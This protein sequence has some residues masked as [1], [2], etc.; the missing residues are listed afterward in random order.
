MDG[1]VPDS[2]EVDQLLLDGQQRLRSLSNALAGKGTLRYYFEV[3]NLA[4]NDLGVREV[5]SH[6]CAQGSGKRYSEEP[7]TAY[8]QNLIPVSILGDQ[9]GGN[10]LGAVSDWCK[11]AL[12]DKPYG[13]VKPLETEIT[14]LRTTLLERPLFYCYLCRDTPAAVALDV[15]IESNQSSHRLRTFDIVVA[16]SRKTHRDGIRERIERFRSQVPDVPYYFSPERER[17][18]PQIGDWYLKVSCLLNGEA[19]KDGNY[20]DAFHQL[21]KDDDSAR[22]KLDQLESYLARALAFAAAHGAP[23]VRTLPSWPPIHVIAALQRKLDG[24]VQGRPENEFNAERLLSRYL[25]SAYVTE[26][27]RAQAN[28]RLLA[29][30]VGLETCLERISAGE[31]YRNVKVDALNRTRYP[32][33]TRS[34]LESSL[35][36][37]G[38]QNRRARAVAA[39]TARR[40]ALDW[41]TGKQLTATYVRELHDDRKLHFHHVFPK[42]VLEGSFSKETIDNG[43]NGV[44]ISKRQNLV[45]GRSDPR[46]YVERILRIVGEL[47]ASELEENIKSHLIP[48]DIMMADEPVQT[49]YPRFLKE[50]ARLVEREVKKRTRVPAAG[51]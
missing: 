36:W 26:R 46:D 28:D 1:E 4:E 48:Y 44:W 10:G 20:E 25:W 3:E 49:R 30:F 18:I 47:T 5:V 40:G 2:A 11:E 13:V 34:T 41:L 22:R 37:I 6:S 33:P 51:P 31:S 23:T 21:V 27:Y 43:L 29:D 7:Q 16:K 8:A 24:L 17:Y 12:P 35:G 39:V 19:P 38:T 14:N 15:F 42:A 32:L 50:R 45:L 9:G